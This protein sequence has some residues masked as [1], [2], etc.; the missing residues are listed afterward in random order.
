M[1]ENHDDVLSLT[2]PI[3]KEEAFRVHAQAIDYHLTELIADIHLAGDSTGHDAI[4]H[5]LG[6]LGTCHSLMGYLMCHLDRLMDEK[7]YSRSKN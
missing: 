4:A 5:A 3:A 7:K 6:L 1:T 2:S